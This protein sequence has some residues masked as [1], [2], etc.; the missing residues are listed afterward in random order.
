M[1]K[2]VNPEVVFLGTGSM[3]PSKYRNVS[4]IYVEMTPNYS[5]VLDCGEGSYYQLFNHFGE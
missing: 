3:K 4:S 2:E 5:F 1:F